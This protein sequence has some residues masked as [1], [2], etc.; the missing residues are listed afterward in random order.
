MDSCSVCK[1]GVTSHEDA[2]CRPFR[3]WNEI[4]F[5]GIDRLEQDSKIQISMIQSFDDISGIP[6]VELKSYIRVLLPD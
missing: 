1:R 2:P 5:G 3:Q 6:A 4:I